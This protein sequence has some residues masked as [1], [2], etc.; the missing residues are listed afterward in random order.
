MKDIPG[1]IAMVRGWGRIM[2]EPLDAGSPE[3]G[4][5]RLGSWCGS[6]SCQR[7]ITQLGSLAL[8]LHSPS[9][10]L[11]ACQLPVLARLPLLTRT[12]SRP[13]S[14][15]SSTIPHSHLTYFCTDSSGPLSLPLLP[16]FL[17][18]SHSKG[19]WT[20]TSNLS[21][22]T[23]RAVSPRYYLRGHQQET[24]PASLLRF[25]PSPDEGC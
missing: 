4:G 25:P 22:S 1:E 17:L 11:P 10:C 23:L 15:L 7:F 8:S 14:G 12:F 2:E 5:R 3:S 20:H 24:T 21:S 18:K 16:P 6:W 9:K 13:T 19:S